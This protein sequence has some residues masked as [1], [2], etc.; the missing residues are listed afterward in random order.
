MRPWVVKALTTT[1]AWVGFEAESQVCFIMFYIH[2]YSKN[3]NV[4]KQMKPFLVNNLTTPNL[5]K[6]FKG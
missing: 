3:D 4:S 2:I 1:L 6:P 5:L